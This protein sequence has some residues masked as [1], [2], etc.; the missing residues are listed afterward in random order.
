M[1]FGLLTGGSS[2]ELR[3]DLRYWEMLEELEL[4]DRLGFDFFGCPEQHFLG[5]ACST[6][7]AECFYGAAAMRT[8]RIRI[9]P[10]KGHR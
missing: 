10:P 2:A 1:R 4:A 5:E 6:S 8:K 9:T 7:A 3:H